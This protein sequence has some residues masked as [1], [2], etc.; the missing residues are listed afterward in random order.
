MATTRY[1]AITSDEDGFVSM[2]VFDTAAEAVK[3]VSDQSFLQFSQVTAF[4]G[5]LLSVDGGQDGFT[6]N[7]GDRAKVVYQMMEGDV[8]IPFE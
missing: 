6:V 5:E 7:D 3:H 4:E 2:K 1:L 8:T